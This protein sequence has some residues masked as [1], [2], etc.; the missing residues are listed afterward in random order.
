MKKLSIVIPTRDRPSF[1]DMSLQFMCEQDSSEFEVVLLDN[2]SSNET[3]C[4][5]L[6]QRD[7][8]FDIVYS[9]ADKQLS[10]VDNWSRWSGLA[11]GE[12]V[13]FI[14]DRAFF[15][16]GAIDSL[17]EI[18]SQTS[19]DLH[20]IH[21]VIFYPNVPRDCMS[22][23][24]YLLDGRGWDIGLLEYVPSEWLEYLYEW[25]CGYFDLP[26]WLSTRGMIFYGVASRNLLNELSTK[27]GSLF[28][29]ASPE[30]TSRILLLDS[31]RSGAS[32]TKPLLVAPY[33][34]SGNASLM[35]KD[36]AAA[37]SYYDTLNG[38]DQNLLILQMLIPNLL[39]V[40]NLCS[41]ELSFYQQALDLPFSLN[42]VNS[43]ALILDDIVTL[44]DGLGIARENKRAVDLFYEHLEAKGTV[45]VKKVEAASANLGK[46]RAKLL[47]DK[48]ER[49]S[50]FPKVYLDS[51]NDCLKF[52][53][54]RK[55]R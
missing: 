11:S 8:P 29:F 37:K 13:S 55:E 38:S 10:M 46:Y 17:L 5:P 50:S 35:R 12:K 32:I 51:M 53:A 7:Y 15:L 45:F 34:N 18:I 25:E 36:Y 23:S 48:N 40:H 9:R 31:A 2:P 42:M 27:N 54:G 26:P 39:T 21:P 6:M 43:Y 28:R 52:L 4:L 22:S 47:R 19:H 16:P 33:F 20:N 1:V 14:P 49:I 44:K 30:N 24:G 3:S 41:A